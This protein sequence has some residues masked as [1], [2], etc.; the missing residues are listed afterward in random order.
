M[1]GY[2]IR[3]TKWIPDRDDLFST[4]AGLHKGGYETTIKERDTSEGRQYAVYRTLSKKELDEIAKGKYKL[5]GE[6][7]LRVLSEDLKMQHYDVECT[8]P[9]C[10]KTYIGHNCERRSYCH[11]CIAKA[12][13]LSSAMGLFEGNTGKK[14]T[15]RPSA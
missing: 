13:N 14:G 7:I 6:N 8:C 10:G 12:Q 3:V 11:N 9:S 2:R 5:R 1:E 15:G 4:I